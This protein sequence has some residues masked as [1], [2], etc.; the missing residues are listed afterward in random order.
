VGHFLIGLGC[1][2]SGEDFSG[3]A[4][5]LQQFKPNLPGLIGEPAINAAP[6]CL[7]PLYLFGLIFFAGAALLCMSLL[8]GYSSVYSISVFAFLPLV[9]WYSRYVHVDIIYWAFVVL[10]LLF[11]WRGYSRSE[12]EY[13]N[14]SLAAAMFA[15]ATAA[16]FMAGAFFLFLLFLYYEKKM[17]RK[18]STYDAG[19]KTVKGLILFIIVFAA[20]FMA[21]FNFNPQ[22]VFD[23]YNAHS[24]IYSEQTA[25]TMNLNFLTSFKEFIL[26]LNPF[27]FFI[28]I[29]SI[30]IF[31]VLLFRKN[32]EN[33]EKFIMYFVLFY[34]VIGILF[35]NLF[36][37]LYLALP[38]YI[39]LVLLMGLTF[40][41]RDYSVFKKLKVKKEYFLWFMM[42]YIAFSFVSNAALSPNY[43]LNTNVLFNSFERSYT[44]FGEN[45]LQLASF[46]KTTLKENETFY[47]PDVRQDILY[48][49]LQRDFALA[50]FAFEQN[51]KNE[52]G[53]DPTI[54]E[55]VDIFNSNGIDIR[56]LILN[57]A[58]VYK[59]EQMS[60]ILRTCEPI[61]AIPIKAD[62]KDVAL[63]YD[64]NICNP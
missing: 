2:S 46:L 57:K 1:I 54:S 53:R 9:L 4:G 3:A 49:Y 27:D 51:F 24:S 37:S 7:L 32:K 50:Q 20:M 15:L 44:I 41:D 59:D 11:L 40:S 34:L 23:V 64:L 36:G 55:R 29:Y 45:T 62:G 26:Y 17:F 61:E 52:V 30:F 43:M 38:F 16:K 63:I 35:G 39:S 47:Y 58:R 25:I 14:F 21:P 42:L 48:F 8:K 10:G 60:N 12:K 19:I 56:Y 6:Y 5:I 28:L 18:E 22:N 33:N 31:L 13:L